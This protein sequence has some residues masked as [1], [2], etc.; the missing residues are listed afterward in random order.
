M[1]NNSVNTYGDVL[2]EAVCPV[3]YSDTYKFN[4]FAFKRNLPGIIVIYAIIFLLDVTSQLP[5]LLAG[6]RF[7][8]T[9][10]IFLLLFIPL[11]IFFTYITTRKAIRATLQSPMLI[12]NVNRFLFYQD[13]MENIDNQSR[14]VVFY[15]QFINAYETDEYFYLFIEKNRAFIIGKYGFTY[16]T[17]EE[18]RKLLAIKLGNRFIVKTK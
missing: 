14:T 2:F 13:C 17:P 7:D 10:I 18:M 11:F 5:G 1:G 12:N 8:F 6:E 16:N 15:N 4:L 9:A 3:S